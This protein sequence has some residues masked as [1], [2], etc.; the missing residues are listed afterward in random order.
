MIERIFK[1]VFKQ[2]TSNQYLLMLFMFI[3]VTQRTTTLYPRNFE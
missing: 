3:T 2:A 1:I